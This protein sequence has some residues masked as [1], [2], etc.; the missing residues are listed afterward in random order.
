M[1]ATV[2]RAEYEAA[3][4]QKQG[5]IDAL[6]HELAE[7]KRLIFAAKSERFVPA[8]PVAE[9]M[10]LWDQ[11]LPH[12]D[13]ACGGQ[14]ATEKISYQRRR[15]SKAKQSHPGRTL[16]P[17]HFPV[18]QIR[19]EPPGQNTSDLIEIGQDITRKVD[20]TPGKLEVIE[21][22]RPR[23]V[24]PAAKVSQHEEEEYA[25]GSAVIQA[26]APD[27]VLPKAIAGAGLLTQLAI[28]KFIDHLPL[29]RQRAMF[30]RDYDWNIPSSTLGD[31]FAATCALLEPL[32]AALEKQ[33]LD[34]DYLQ[35]DE[36]RITVLERGA[37]P[38]KNN[39][40]RYP[41]KFRKVHLGYMWVFRNPVAGGVLFAYR[42]GRGANILHETLDSFGGILQSDGY[43][44]YTSFMKK[45]PAVALVSCLAHIR[46]KFF[47][48]RS[49]HPELAELAL[50]AIQYLYRIEDICC[51]YGLDPERRR[52]LRQRSA[53]PAYTALLEWVNEQ[54][55]TS[56]SKG[57]IGKALSYAHNH[58]PRLGA[59]LDDGRIEIDNNLIENKIRP[60]ALGRKNY[61]FAGSRD[62]ARR[63]AMLYSFFGSC[64]EAGVNERE[65][66]QDVLLRIGQHPINRI[67]ELL[68]GRWKAKV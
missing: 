19:V 18:R 23:Y 7:L 67:E 1:E 12:D 52:W 5:Q 66:L 56:L 42:P 35:G 39:S 34:T 29:Y 57:G 4:R 13:A 26:P 62:G 16:L 60:L 21:Y 3:I 50:R 28:A 33:V 46:R 38:T 54:R 36:S 68:P 40:H 63:A 30:R 58:L 6:R 9:Q 20:Y 32:Y 65:W 61:L 49:N 48:A 45:H 14:P 25:Q 27:Q 44:A 22:V 64:R 43:S 51:R 31:W 24:H 41:P 55:R 2:S 47:D 59:Y 11:E 37:E 17:E 15:R 10:A 8:A 53:R